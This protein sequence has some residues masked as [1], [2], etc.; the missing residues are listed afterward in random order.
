MRADQ[1]PHGQDAPRVSVCGWRGVGQGG[2]RGGGV[3]GGIAGGTRTGG[4][5]RQMGDSEGGLPAQSRPPARPPIHAHTCVDAALAVKDDVAA[6]GVGVGGWVG[7]VGG[8]GEQSSLLR[9]TT[10]SSSSSDSSSVHRG[11][12]P[13]T[14]TLT[15]QSRRA[16]RAW[17]A[18]ACVC[19]CV[20]GWVGLLLCTRCTPTHPHPTTHTDPPT[21]PRPP[22]Q[23]HPPTRLPGVPEVGVLS[24]TS[25]PP[26][27]HTYTPCN[28]DAHT[29]ALT[30][31]HTHTPPRC[32]RGGGTCP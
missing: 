27:T 28:P 13:H 11:A 24:Y 26:N 12:P 30:H 9:P 15:A 6:W 16:P 21:H 17:A 25:T 18:P 7:G 10:S 3:E 31:T 4:P 1:A 23:T 22:T 14:H 5:R 20:A 19:V 2:G 8:W 29:H 32:P